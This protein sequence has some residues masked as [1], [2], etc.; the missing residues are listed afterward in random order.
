[1]AFGVPGCMMTSMASQPVRFSAF[2]TGGLMI[3]VWLYVAFFDNPFGGHVDVL[4][5]NLYG[6]LGLLIAAGV[7]AARQATLQW[8]I[9]IVIGL[10]ITVGFLF[11]AGITRESGEV[12]A[13]AF[14]LAGGALIVSGIP[15]ALAEQA[16]GWT[17][18]EDR[19]L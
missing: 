6:L 18:A 15:S 10:G 16:P 4:E 9:A 11:L 1:M 5:W 13:A 3:S 12:L 19:T 8:R 14:T 7:W 2:F 17:N